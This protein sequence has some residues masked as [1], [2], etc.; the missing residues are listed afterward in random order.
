MARHDALRSRRDRRCAMSG[1]G[2]F[3]RTLV[4][5]DRGRRGGHRG[6]DLPGAL[7]GSFGDKWMWS[8]G[9]AAPPLVAAG[10]AGVFSERAARTAL[11]VRPGCTRPTACSGSTSTHAARLRKPGGLREPLQPGDGPADAR[12]PARWP[13][14]AGWA[15]SRRCCAGS[16]DAEPR[17][18]ACRRTCR[19]CGRATA[20]TPRL[21]RQRRGTTPQMLGRYPDFDVLEAGD[22]WDEA[23]R[24][25]VLARLDAVPPARFFTAAEEPTLA[26]SATRSWPRT[27]SRASPCPSWSTSKLAEGGLEGYRY[28]GMPDDGDD[29]RS[30]SPGWTTTARDRRRRGFAALTTERRRGSSR[31]SRGGDCAAARGTTFDRS[32]LERRDARRA[33]GV[34]CPPLGVERDRLRRPRLSARVRCGWGW[35]RARAGRA[36]RPFDDRSGRRRPSR[37]GRGD[38]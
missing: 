30:C 5:A 9:R 6:R 29:W 15:C 24:K 4:R 25:V 2:R 17:R 20:R 12:R 16:G 33:G 34:L 26:P 10:I 13:W 21:P 7:R 28:A 1:T 3:E 38:E 11:P 18:H 36:L 31:R 27:A 37:R 32:G 14:S 19:S 8:A 22:A 35:R 23:T